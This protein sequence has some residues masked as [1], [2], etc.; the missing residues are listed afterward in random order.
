MVKRN[1]CFTN[2]FG[3]T[4]HSNYARIARELGQYLNNTLNVSTFNLTGLKKVTK[5]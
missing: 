2:L 3:F 5:P 4:V 1:E